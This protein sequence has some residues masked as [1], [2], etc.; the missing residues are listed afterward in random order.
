MSDTSY[1]YIGTQDAGSTANEHNTR[2]F[3]ID[4][5]NAQQRSKTPV[6]VV[7]APYDA[8]GNDIPPGTIGPIGFID[9]HPLV[10]QVDGN[11]NATPH[12][13]I[14][15]SPYHRYQSGNGA[16][17]SDPV[18]DDIGD[19]V[20]DDRDTSVVY[21]T[22]AQG[23]PGSGLKSSL[24]NGTYHGQTSAGTPT[25]G[26]RFT[27]TGMQF[28][29]KNGNTITSSASGWVFAD[30]SGDTITMAGGVITLKA[31][32]IIETNGGSPSPVVTVAGNSPIAKADG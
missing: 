32:S 11:G 21:A 16:I 28:F 19:Y 30:A 1:A 9:V 26:L 14:Y 15:H 3:Q 12:G 8:S 25:Q 24:S 20:V 2:Q 13:T 5:T 10:N 4:Q 7:R 17:I 23:N 29:D 31:P 6:K 22:G 27:A 18:V